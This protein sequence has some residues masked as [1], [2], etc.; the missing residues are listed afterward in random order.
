MN[1]EAGQLARPTSSGPYVV[2]SFPV[3]LEDNYIVVEA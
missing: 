3:R 1:V 2:Q